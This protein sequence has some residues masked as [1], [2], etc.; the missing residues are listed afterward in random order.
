[1]CDSTNYTIRF[2]ISLC[3]G[4]L[5]TYTDTCYWDSCHHLEMC[6]HTMV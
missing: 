4:I 1:M 5:S 6:G 3:F 2:K